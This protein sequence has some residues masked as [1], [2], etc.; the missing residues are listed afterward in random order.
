MFDR[1]YL[2]PHAIAHWAKATPDAV[3]LQHVEG[4][5]LTYGQLLEESLRWAA[6]Y[7]M[8]GIGAGD[9]VGLMLPHGM[10]VPPA[11][12]GLGWLR[13][14]EVPLNTAYLGRMLQYALSL[15]DVTTLVI[16]VGYLDRLEAVV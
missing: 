15:A 4:P 3:A 16:D 8:S 9:H 1:R 12:L 2:A 13:A 7:R 10:T 5:S 6:A 11:W 14:V